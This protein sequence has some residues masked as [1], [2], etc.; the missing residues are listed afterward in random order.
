M[1]SRRTFVSGALAALAL[2]AALPAVA[3]APP[4]W[5]AR[6]IRSVTAKGVLGTSPATFRPQDA[7]TQGALAQAIAAVDKLV[8]P[9]APPVTIVSTV[10]AGATIGGEVRWTADA[11]NQHVENVD[12]LVDG[13]VS[14]SQEWEPYTFA[15][16]TRSL[17][18]GA[19]TFAVTFTLEDDAT[20][21]ASWPVTIANAAGVVVPPLSGAP[22]AVPITSRPA[23]Q[24]RSLYK[25]ASPSRAVT[26]KQ[27]DAA[28]VNYLG[29]SDAAASVQGRL[30]AAGLE[31]PAGTGSEVV[32]RLLGLRTNHPAGQDSLEPLPWDPATRAEAAFSF[33]QLVSLQSWAKDSVA[34]AAA[35]FTVAP[36]DAWQQ[37]ILRT[38]VHYVG[39]PYVWGGTSP[40]SETLF[41]VTSRGG[42]DCSGFVWRVYKLTSYPGSGA[43]ASVLHGRTTYQ[44]SG[45]VGPAKRI[46]AAKLAPGDV[47]FFG[48]G[49]HSLPSQVDHAG[50]YLGNGWMV[51][52]SGNGV[53]IV[54]FAGWYEH[55]FAWARRPLHEAALD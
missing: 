23:V 13:V 47:V 50:I 32:A 31:P 45:E 36:L 4:D 12:F 49:P 53:T 37:K 55:G 20:Y 34:S 24:Q 30:S 22:A 15:L 41:G 33:A 6:E 54:P 3:A 2:A 38:A 27:L 11:P 19:H 14:E 21:T 9:P 35:S 10:P 46:T 26:I 40:S 16:D 7:L 51:H 28:L 48:N 44:M 5:A 52:S 29:L 1:S 18:D 25:A 42:F 43:L 8:T 39:Y 17:A